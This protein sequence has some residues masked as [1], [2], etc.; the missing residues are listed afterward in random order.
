MAH[1][2]GA[3]FRPG[4]IFKTWAELT[5]RKAFYTENTIGSLAKFMFQPGLKNLV[6]FTCRLHVFIF[7]YYYFFF[8]SVW[9]G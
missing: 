7:Y 9:A 5:C 6:A 8:R 2:P 1:P 4:A 3:I